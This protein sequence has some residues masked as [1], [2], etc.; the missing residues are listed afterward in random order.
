MESVFS[1]ALSASEEAMAE[2]EEVILYAF[3]QCVYYVS[4]VRL[5]STPL[6]G[7]WPG[8]RPLAPPHCHPLSRLRLD[9][10]GP[11]S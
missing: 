8:S 6:L 10:Q 7:A 11:Q 2:L 4:K 9:A 3:Q 1:C 5:R